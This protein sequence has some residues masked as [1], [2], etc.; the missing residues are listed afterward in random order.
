MTQD[1]TQSQHNVDNPHTFGSPH[2]FGNPIDCAKRVITMEA[3]ALHALA[4]GL[5]DS[6]TQAIE[7]LANQT[8]RVIV[9]G[10]GKNGHI[11]NKITATLA[12]T[13][14]TAHFVHPA[15]ASHGD[16][17]MISKNDTVIALSNSGETTELSDLIAYTRR[18][19]IPLIAITS[20]PNSTLGKTADIVLALPP[21]KEACPNGQAPTTSTTATL[22][23]GDAIAIALLEKRGFSAE[24]FGVFHPGGKLGKQLVKVSDIMHNLDQ[25]P[26]ISPDTTMGNA[27]VIMAEK[28]FGCL[29][30]TDKDYT[31]LGA[32]TDGDLRRNMSPKL[33]E[34]PAK[35]VMTTTPTTLSADVMAAEAL[36][37]LNHKKINVV[38]ITDGNNK[39]QGVLHIHDLLTAGIV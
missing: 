15:E 1:N 5:N 9:S 30:V 39:I 24:D 18:F 33:P 35:D 11:G 32:I 16:L 3:D 13:G 19:S 20:N 25:T 38:F 29:A 34:T 2:T 4:Q 23:L 28:N 14:T 17:G 27:L 6:F 8:G 21:M 31:L 10:M 12:S 36:A 26:T 7:C 37:L 22:A